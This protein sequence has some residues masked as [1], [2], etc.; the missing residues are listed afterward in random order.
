M[1]MTD[2]QTATDAQVEAAYAILREEAAL[3]FSVSVRD[4]IPTSHYEE[5]DLARLKTADL[6]AEQKN[7]DF[8]RSIVEAAL[9]ASS[10][11][12]RELIE[13]AKDRLLR[14]SWGDSEKRLEAAVRAFDGDFRVHPERCGWRPAPNPNPSPHRPPDPPVACGQLKGH[15][16]PHRTWQGAIIVDRFGSDKTDV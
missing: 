16:G 3:P 6:A 12:V 13:A 11:A 2:Y 8:A 5:R 4:Y 9:N 7:R 14:P 1:P 15:D 10:S